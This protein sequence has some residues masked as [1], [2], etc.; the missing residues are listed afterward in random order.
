MK[1]ERTFLDIK[2]NRSLFISE[3][4]LIRDSYLPL[5]NLKK[6]KTEKKRRKIFQNQER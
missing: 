2:A 4:K 5:L 1:T 3:N 6:K